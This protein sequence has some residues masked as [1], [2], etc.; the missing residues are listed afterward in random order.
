MQGRGGFGTEFM[1]H[2]NVHYALPN[3][4]EHHGEPSMNHAGMARSAA[5]VEVHGTDRCMCCDK[6][7]SNPWVRYEWADFDWY[8]RE[9]PTK[10]WR[11]IFKISP[12]RRRTFYSTQNLTRFSKNLTN[13]TDI[14][15]ESD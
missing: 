11:K 6:N 10:T 3:M 5:S 12:R 14:L 13:L 2:H 8:N 9:N 15:E 7:F 4:L 1:L